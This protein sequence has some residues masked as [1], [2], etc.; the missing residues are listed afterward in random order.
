MD[1]AEL[2]DPK[3]TESDEEQPQRRIQHGSDGMYRCWMTGDGGR[4]V[5][6]VRPM[7]WR[8]V[9]MKGGEYYVS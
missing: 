6:S 8:S 9:E 2:R 3:C 5:E 7:A 4:S 1:R